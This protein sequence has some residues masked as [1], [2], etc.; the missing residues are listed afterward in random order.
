MPDTRQRVL[1]VAPVPPP[2][3]GAAYAM[4]FLLTGRVADEFRLLH[5]DSRFTEDVG[6]LQ[7]F[8]FNKL[9]RL[10]RYCWQIAKHS[11]SGRAK[12]VVLTPTF[13]FKPFLKDAVFVW[14]CWL[15]RRRIT[16]WIHMDFRA[17]KYDALPR[18]GRWFV[19]TTL[20]RC[21]R[22]VVP[23]ERLIAFMPRWIANDRLWALPNGLPDHPAFPPRSADS[24]PL[25]VLYLS[26]IEDNKGWRTFLE[27]VRTVG[28]EFP[29]TE[30]VLH[31]RPI[32]GVTD[33]A[34]RTEIARDD[35]NGCLRWLGP[36]LGDEKWNAF[37]T[38]DL[39]CFPSWHE[40]FPLAILEAM[41]AGLPVVTSEVGGVPDAVV[42]GEGG[43]IV[44]PRDA[45]ALA[46][47]LRRLLSDGALRGRMGRFNR[48]RWEQHY[49][50][51]A[52]RA[53]WSQFLH[54][55]LDAPVA[56]AP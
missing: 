53:R 12:S 5:V 37:A 7:K 22:V 34:V 30:F 41:C 25:R 44:P 28:R 2:V 38:A 17:M 14:L 40:A 56:T 39:F 15:L 42:A 51:E 16:A 50:V 49:T 21:E 26:N 32:L 19:K 29:G 13:Y 23:A 20:R 4:Q 36:V 33:D 43:I 27:A 45:A 46:D 6:A 47:G 9:T 18:W 54:G 55:W 48:I 11:L 31:G 8:S 10:F 35:L 52:Y 24:R 1:F 3:H